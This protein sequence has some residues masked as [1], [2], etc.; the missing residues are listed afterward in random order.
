MVCRK[1]A[2]ITSLIRLDSTVGGL[3]QPRIAYGRRARGEGEGAGCFNEVNQAASQASYNC[4]QAEVHSVIPITIFSSQNLEKKT[5]LRYAY[6]AKVVREAGILVALIAR[7]SAIPG[8][9]TPSS[10]FLHHRH[11][12]RCPQSLPLSSRHAV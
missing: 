2:L 1:P 11:V 7:Y 12:S 9:C 4:Q 5:V 6:L 10:V 3:S 8:H